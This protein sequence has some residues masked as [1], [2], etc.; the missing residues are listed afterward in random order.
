[1]MQKEQSTQA[2]TDPQTPSSGIDKVVADV[3]AKFH[4]AKTARKEHEERWATAY[5]N[6]RGKYDKSV[7]F[8]ENEKSRAFIK[9][10]KT[11]VLAAYGQMIDALFA[12]GKLPL[13]VSKTEVAK[14]KIA[15]AVET[16]L[17]EEE[18]VEEPVGIGWAG[19]GREAPLKGSLGMPPSA[20][21]AE[22]L[23]A[24][25]SPSMA[26]S[27]PPMEQEEE[28]EE[29]KARDAAKEMERLIHD[30]LDASNSKKVIR[31][32]MFESI[33]LGTGVVKGP[34]TTTKTIN[35]WVD[36]EL[37]QEEVSFPYIE[38]CSVWSYYPDPNANFT[39]EVEW[40]VQ[41]HKLSRSQMIALASNK[42][43]NK[44]AIREVVKG[45][46][47][48][49][50]RDF[51]NEVQMEDQAIGVD[52]GDRWEVL[53]YWGPAP[54]DESNDELL[55]V[56]INAWVCGGKIIRINENPFTPVRIPYLVFPFEKNPYSLF[57][58]GVAE[59]MDDFQ[60]L[61]NGTTRMAIDNAA[62]SGDLVFDIDESALAPGQDYTIY[63]GKKFVRQSGMP[64]QAIHGITFP[65]T[66]Q[67]NMMMFDR[68]RQLADEATGIPSYSHGNTGVTGMTRTAS[69]MSMLMSASSLNIKTAIKNIDDFLLEPLG[70]SMFYWNMQFYEGDLDITG[71][72]EVRAT[73]SQS[74]VQK[75][76][77][78]Q[79]LLSF[80]QLASNPQIAPMVNMRNLIKEI[81]YTMELNTE[82][83]LNDMEQAEEQ[84]RIVGMQ[85]QMAQQQ[86]AML[87]GATGNGDGTIGTGIV[88]QP[89]EA[90][91]AANQPLD[92]PS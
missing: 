10:T 66:S 51:E 13:S 14:T 74:L 56:N 29:D 39:G 70:R 25:S 22:P 1:M 53:E 83:I 69:G 76:V 27:M 4:A 68:W 81:A 11:K 43:F 62:L 33:L 15:T 90:E 32:A 82:G 47:N 48:Y 55:N 54:I 61:M 77:K 79:R 91:F 75:E 6:Y 38:F 2:T 78:S 73:G 23:Q 64:G 88:P 42:M 26:P 60:K 46:G 87:G 20:G 44:E 16:E 40:S 5:H 34:F 41:R 50:N 85:N 49:Q 21:I 58:V 92:I 63:P 71:D 30:Q 84:A 19:D 80:L 59:N 35:S 8:R 18:V 24:P 37:K 12:S 86:Q 36:G 45:G 31:D 52:G 9:I 89:G 17:A 7:A 3:E 65:N 67:Q 28:S 57:G 72:L